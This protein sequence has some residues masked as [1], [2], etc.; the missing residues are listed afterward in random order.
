[1]H[2]FYELL[3]LVEGLL[4]VGI[5]IAY[6]QITKAQVGIRNQFVIREL[7]HKRWNNLMAFRLSEEP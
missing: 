4:L 7:H 6:G 2:N 1:M 5:H 3:N